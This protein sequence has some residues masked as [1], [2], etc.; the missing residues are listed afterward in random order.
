MRIICDEEAPVWNERCKVNLFHGN[1]NVTVLRFS[2]S[3]AH[4]AN[5][6]STACR[7][8]VVIAM[9]QQSCGASRN[10]RL[11][12]L[13]LPHAG[14]RGARSARGH[15]APAAAAHEESEGQPGCRPGAY[16]G[17]APCGR[18]A[19]AESSLVVLILM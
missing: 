12:R 2:T 13:V 7:H 15:G 4:D 18:C 5:V 10:L 14:G 1:K 6:T 19:N 3:A 16:S 11:R 17:R 9:H 8:G